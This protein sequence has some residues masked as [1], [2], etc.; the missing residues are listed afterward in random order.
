MDQEGH[1]AGPV[2]AR[3]PLGAHA[4]EQPCGVTGPALLDPEVVH[5]HHTAPGGHPCHEPDQ[6]GI[7]HGGEVLLED[8]EYDGG[9]REHA[10]EQVQFAAA[11]G[12]VEG[13][14]RD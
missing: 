10:D 2:E 4:V 1:D 14:G 3:K 7:Q 8:E 6:P 13:L 9:E 5:Q 12:D 11:D